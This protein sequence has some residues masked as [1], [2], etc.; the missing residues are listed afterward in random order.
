MHVAAQTLDSQ[1]KENKED[2]N[3]GRPG[4]CPTNDISIEF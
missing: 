2:T 4:P 1:C 3:A